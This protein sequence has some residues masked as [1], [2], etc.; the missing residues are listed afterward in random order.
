MFNKKIT[1]VATGFVDSG[2]DFGSSSVQL[3]SNKK[4]ALLSGEGTSSLSVGEI[5]HFFEQQ[6]KYPLHVINTASLGRTDLSNYDVLILP[7]RYRAG[8]SQ[9]KSFS[10]FASNGGNVIAIGSAVNSF[11]DKKGFGLKKKK[12]G[13]DKDKDEKNNFTINHYTC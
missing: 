12:A 2:A 8:E 7:N 4:I 6:L 5:W 1:P 9:L 13:D 3:V 11:A 10:E